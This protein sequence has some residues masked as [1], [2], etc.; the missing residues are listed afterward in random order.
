MRDGIDL[1]LLCPHER[2]SGVL[3]PSVGPPAQVRCGAVGEGP[4]EGH[5]DDLGAGAPHLGRQAEGTDLVQ[6]RKENVAERPQ[7]SLPVF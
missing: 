2:P 7:Y 5:R 1:P 4:E 6:P 3:C